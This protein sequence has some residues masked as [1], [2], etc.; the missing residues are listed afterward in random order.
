MALFE[1]DTLP[2]GKMLIPSVIG[3]QPND[4]EHPELVAQRFG[5]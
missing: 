5:R 1:T 2:E 3:C 4:I